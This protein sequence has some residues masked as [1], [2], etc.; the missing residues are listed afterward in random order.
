MT[1]LFI[2]DLH[3]GSKRFKNKDGLKE[4]L[5]N[6]YSHRYLLGDIIDT[7]DENWQVIVKKHEDLIEL[8]NELKCNI[9][10][11]NHDPKVG[12]MRYIFPN[13]TVRES[14]FR[15]YSGKPCILLHG[16]LYHTWCHMYHYISGIFRNVPSVRNWIT[17]IYEN[18]NYRQ[19]QHNILGWDEKKTIKKMYLRYRIIIMGHTHTPKIINTPHVQYINTGSWVR[20]PT[21]VEYEGKNF[22]LIWV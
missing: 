1:E 21:F 7:Y 4:I 16:D 18:Y 9:A 17:D 6:P 20:K 5:K 19:F 22:K 3:I 8:I 12:I 15:V 11:G 13:C 10:I 2:S 14:F